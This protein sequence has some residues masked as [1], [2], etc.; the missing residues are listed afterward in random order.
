MGIIQE[1]END[2]NGMCRILEKL[3]EYVPQQS[4]TEKTLLENGIEIEYE[5]YKFC[6]LVMAGD[7]L[8][9]ARIRGAQA[10]RSHGDNNLE[11]LNGFVP[12]TMDWHA[13]VTLLKVLASQSDTCKYM[14]IY[15]LFGFDFWMSTLLQIKEHLHSCTDKGTFAQLINLLFRT[16]VPK[17]EPMR[18]VKAA[19]D[20]LQLIL[21]AYTI[22]AADTVTAKFT[23]RPDVLA[24]AKLIVSNYCSLLI[25]NN[26][27]DDTHTAPD[28]VLVYSKELLTLS[29]LW[30]GFYDSIKE[31]DGERVKRYWKF[32]LLL[33]KASKRRN[34]AVEAANF[35]INETLYPPRLKNQML[36][37]RFV[38]VKG[39]QGCNIPLD[40]HMEHMN[41]RV[42]AAL[43]N[44]NSNV[45]PNSIDR[46]GKSIGVI[47][48]ICSI[49]EET[50]S[51]GAER[52]K[53]ACWKKD[54]NEILECLRSVQPFM[55]I[56]GRRHKH[57][58][59]NKGLLEC[60]NV[61]TVI[62]WLNDQYK[63]RPRHV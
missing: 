60:I 21:T 38:N 17:E 57:F 47:R 33:F 45:T 6:H 46:I 26:S 13:K 58:S 56:P 16:S 51:P 20:F 28:C 15:R 11:K 8:T 25:G 30:F 27:N 22:N 48:N 1:N 52:H 36:W 59:F 12:A 23:S 29:L 40:L 18:N 61:K 35:L 19:E 44:L 31:G 42:K 63:S 10:V 7:Q 9:C 53:K 5:T 49:F 39:R 32:M 54:L 3:H 50:K 55:N 24:T 2:I 34:Y 43:R 62:T 41:R 37:S 14:H 4:E